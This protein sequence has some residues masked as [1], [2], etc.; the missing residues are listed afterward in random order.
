MTSAPEVSTALGRVRGTTTDGIDRF[1]GLPYAA[2]PVGPNRFRA[3]QPPAAHTGVFAA[4]RFGPPPPQF[5]PDGQ[6]PLADHRDGDD[7]LTL[8]VWAPAGSPVEQPDGAGEGLP[9]IVWIHGGAYIQGSSAEPTYDGTPFARLGCVFVTLNYRLG[10]EGFLHFPASPETIDFPSNRGLLDQV[11]ALS[12]VREN[13]AAF[14]GDPDRV[15]LM[16]ESAG[17]GSVQA[18]LAMPAA[19]GLFRRAILQSPPAMFIDSALA[20][21]ATELFADAAGLEPTPEAFARIEP[22]RF[23]ALTARYI[24]AQREH[25][26]ELGRASA[27]EPL[28]CPVVDGLTLPADPWESLAHGASRDAEVI[29]GH[30]SDEF[31]LF[32]AYRPREVDAGLAQARLAAL[33]PA[34]ALEAY[35]ALFEGREPEDLYEAVQS[36]WVFTVP[37][38]QLAQAHAEAGGATYAYLLALTPEGGI[39]S[40][41]AADVPLIFDQFDSDMGRLIYPRP[42]AA[43]RRVGE[44]LRE[45]WVRFAAT[46]DPGWPAWD[47]SHAVRIFDAE[48]HDGPYPLLARW[49]AY[50]EDRAHA[51]G[52]QPAAR[53]EP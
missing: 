1:L 14:G 12:W 3:P 36:D 17:A 23:E 34:G 45:A 30:N 15:T 19:R 33:G 24:S 53:P 13:I 11:A 26:S 31:R 4:D 18:L 47:A 35:A 39:G 21:R 7:W 28:L 48:P 52:L 9:V 50:A 38:M 20:A 22:A 46:G 42:S 2:P 5:A 25:R 27:F 43:E 51:L 29:I 40:A 32:M 16:G 37:A 10:V 49:Q 6:A 41:H 8:N 44:Q